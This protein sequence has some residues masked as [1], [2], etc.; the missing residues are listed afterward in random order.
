MR[1]RMLA[2]KLVGKTFDCWAA[3]IVPASAPT[4]APKLIAITL[5]TRVGTVIAPAASSSSRTDRQPR[6]VRDS[7]RK[8]NKPTSTAKTTSAK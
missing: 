5:T 3:K 6:P 8:C 2:V 7:S 4:A 1:M